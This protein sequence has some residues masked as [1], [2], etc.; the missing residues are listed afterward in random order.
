MGVKITDMTQ[1][2][3]VDGTEVIPCSKSAAPRAFTAAELKS[4][5]VDQI[6]AI[7]AVG[8]V[9]DADGFYMLD[10]TDSALKPVA[11]S[12]VAQH[13][14]DK[15]WGKSDSGTPSGTDEVAIKESGGTEQT[16]TLANLATYIQSA[17]ENAILDVSDV[18]TAG[19]VATT[20][21]VLLTQTTTPKKTTVQALYD[22]IYTG[23]AAHVTGKTD[24]V[25]LQASDEVYV[26]RSGTAYKA[27]LTEIATYV[28]SV[29]TLSG[30]GTNGKLASWTGTTTLADTFGVAD[31]AS[32]FAG[33]SDATIPTSKAVRDEMDEIVND[34]TPLDNA[35]VN[36]DTILVD[37]GANGTQR[38]ATLTQLKTWI[39]TRQ[40]YRTMFIPAALMH[41]RTTAGAAAAAVNEYATNDVNLKYFA[42]DGAT[43]EAVQFSAIMPEE[44]D[45]GTIKAKFCW[46]SAASST[47][48]DTVEWGLKAGA[49][50]DDD[51]IDAALGT[52][53]VISDALL[54]NDGTDLQ[55]TGAT[56]AITVGGTPAAGDL[57]QFEVTRSVDG[58]DDMTEDA[59]LFGVW[60]QY[61]I[62]SEPA[63]W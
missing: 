18:A 20:D 9:A 42:F 10:A 45:L 27:T 23:L 46:S 57:I 43:E 60:I 5:V 29:V 21:Y 17:I 59:W 24:I 49:L 36:T 26:V 16:C 28:G 62:N 8:V 37:D 11:L 56:P 34:A 4:Y 7:S 52:V 33:G 41:P 38:K 32:G 61:G 1:D 50:S 6:E 55:L 51:A 63:A 48:A 15:V 39:G 54:A 14:I 22:A 25:T 44:W 2:G 47:A 30:S 3:L 53:Q 12:V 19:A 40:R 31:S 58:T 35:L 13:V